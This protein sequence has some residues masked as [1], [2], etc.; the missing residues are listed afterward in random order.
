MSL[1][2]TRG[3]PAE[4][5]PSH[6]GTPRCHAYDDFYIDGSGKRALENSEDTGWT[7]VDIPCGTVLPDEVSPLS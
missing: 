5:L 2:G 4:R 6:G 3:C 7:D 1:P